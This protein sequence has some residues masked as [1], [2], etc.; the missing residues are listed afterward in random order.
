MF[1]LAFGSEFLIWFSTMETVLCTV[2]GKM[3][4]DMEHPWAN[5]LFMV[6]VMISPLSSLHVSS[7]PNL[8]RTAH[9]FHTF[10]SRASI[11]LWMAPHQHWPWQR[12]GGWRRGPRQFC[13]AALGL[14]SSHSKLVWA[15]HA[16]HFLGEEFG[17]GLADYPPGDLS[18]GEGPPGPVALCVLGSG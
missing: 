16:A 14:V 6:W 13:G 15:S 2:K 18:D 4:L 5:P 11:S 12:L 8:K 10:L 7:C 1:T 9:H 3:R 17:S